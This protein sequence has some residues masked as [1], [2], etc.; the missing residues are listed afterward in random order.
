MPTVL[1]VSVSN[2][3]RQDWTE[4]VSDTGV[5]LNNCLILSVMSFE[6]HVR[7]KQSVRNCHLWKDSSITTHPTL[8]FSLKLN[9]VISGLLCLIC[10]IVSVTAYQTV[11]YSP[12]LL[13]YRWEHSISRKKFKV[14]RYSIIAHGFVDSMYRS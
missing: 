11:K 10:A 12:H 6:T 8:V 13:G 1:F 14:I 4:T 3:S 7:W 5:P 2:L 9:T